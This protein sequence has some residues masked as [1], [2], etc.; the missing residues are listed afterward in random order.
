MKNKSVKYSVIDITLI[1]MFTALLAICSWTSIQVGL[2]PVTL[3][4]FAIFLIFGLL[5]SKRGTT[6]VLVYILLG[7]CGVP[8]FAG[9][10]STAKLLGPTEV[11]SLDLSLWD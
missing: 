3:Q 5:G 4:T 6:A 1:A 2:I 9:F 10:G 7:L 11:I 8:V